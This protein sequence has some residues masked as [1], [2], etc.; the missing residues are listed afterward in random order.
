MYGNLHRQS[1]RANAVDVRHDITGEEF[2]DRYYEASRSAES[3]GSFLDRHVREVPD[4]A[5]YLERA[6]VTPGGGSSS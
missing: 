5:T 1:G 3:F 4:H 2:I 6:G